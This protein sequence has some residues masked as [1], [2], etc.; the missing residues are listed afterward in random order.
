MLARPSILLPSFAVAAVSAATLLV[1]PDARACGGCFHGE[2]A[3]T[4]PDAGPSQSGT[5]VTDHRMV[6]SVDPTMTTLWDQVEY[7]G[8]PADFAWV[9]PIRGAVKVALGSD[10]FIQALDDATAP[11]IHPP[12]LVCK[13]PPYNYGG[14]SYSGSSGCACGGMSSDDMASPTSAFGGGEDAA[15]QDDSGVVVTDRKSVGPYDTVQLRGDG[16][17]S[18][19]T[20][21]TKNGY[22]VPAAIEPILQKYVDEGFGFVAVR[23]RPGYGVRAMKPIRVSWKGASPQLPLRMVAAG[24]GAK[25]GI[26]LFVVGDGRWRT[27]NFTTFTIGDPELSWDF[28]AGRSNYTELRS[29]KSAALDDHAFALEASLDVSSFGL[30]TSDPPQDDGSLPPDDAGATDSG[31]PSEAGDDAASEASA[32]GADAAAEASDSGAPAIP[33]DASDIEVAFGTIPTRRVTR[34]RADLPVRHLATDLE[35]EADPDQGYRKKD[36]DPARF[37]QETALCPYG[38]VSSSPATATVTTST[39]PS[40]SGAACAVGDRDRESPVGGPVIAAIGLA[41]V[42]LVRARRRR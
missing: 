21:L 26:K 9:L 10:A 20:W 4:T 3:P 29:S 40:A 36:Y 35:L 8:D 39:S 31:A 33:D 15:T 1:T 42:G 6:I 5:V 16:G 11:T 13:S 32:P 19:I 34:L 18:I 24:V 41:V 7:V 17:E 22:V 14:G 28:S 30:P 37:T 27:K 12:Q 2:P 25:V 23:L 38:I